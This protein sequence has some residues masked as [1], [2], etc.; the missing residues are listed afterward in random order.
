MHIPGKQISQNEIFYWFRSSW[1]KKE[2]VRLRQSLKKRIQPFRIIGDIL[3]ETC[4]SKVFFCLVT[5][6]LQQYPS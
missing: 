1:V 2:M 4:V 6:M 5:E 3:L